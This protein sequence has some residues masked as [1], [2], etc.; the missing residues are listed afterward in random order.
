MQLIQ[1]LLVDGNKT[2]GVNNA[3]TY[4]VFF[5]QVLEKR[6]QLVAGASD[7]SWGVGMGEEGR[8]MGCG[9]IPCGLVGVALQFVADC[10]FMEWRCGAC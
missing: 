1:G 9:E 5:G 2:E 7:D 4:G 8:Q 3:L 10:V 6:R